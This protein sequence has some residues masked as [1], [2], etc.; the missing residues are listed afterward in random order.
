MT[1]GGKSTLKSKIR[2]SRKDRDRKSWEL[3]SEVLMA[4]TLAQ[5]K[6]LRR[7]KTRNRKQKS[8]KLSG[9]PVWPELFRVSAQNVKILSPIEKILFYHINSFFNNTKYW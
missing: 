1:V 3:R 2:K 7:C 4:A 8:Q 6:K 5:K 9:G